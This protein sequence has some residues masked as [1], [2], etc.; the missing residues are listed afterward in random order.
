MQP[1]SQPD[2]ATATFEGTDAVE[3]PQRD[4][5]AK[6]RFEINFFQTARIHTEQV[7]E[8]F[9]DRAAAEARA[10]E[11]CKDKGIDPDFEIEEL[12]MPEVSLAEDAE[13]ESENSPEGSDE[14]TT[15]E[16]SLPVN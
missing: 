8:E 10:R 6:P 2:T 13:A 3:T 15:Q 1:D 11:L 16:N 14:K 9:E 5:N 12:P 7:V 4:P